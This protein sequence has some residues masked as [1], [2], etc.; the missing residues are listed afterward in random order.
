MMK[1]VIIGTGAAGISA[2]ETIRQHD[3]QGKIILI[4]DE[5]DG[6][7]SRPG[8]AYLLTSEIPESQLFP[9]SS[10]DFRRLNLHMFKK[11]AGKID[12]QSRK[13]VLQSG[14]TVSYDR[15]LIATGAEARS[16]RVPGV[17]L[18]GVVKLDNVEDARRIIHLAK[19]TRAAVVIGGGITALEIVEGLVHK[20]VKV[21]FF[22]RGD[23]YWGNV[24]DEIESKIVEH[25]LK[26]EGVNI[27][28]HTELEEIIGK[29]SGLFRG[30][31]LRVSA[32][33][34]KA[35]KVIPCAMVAIA[36]GIVPR[37]QLAKDA[38]LKTD[39]GILVDEW[40][41]SDAPDIYAAGDVAQ[42]F[43]PVTGK[44]V[45]DSLW[46]P[47]RLQGQAAGMN[48][49][50]IRTAYRKDFPFNVTRLAGLTTTIIGAVGGKDPDGW[51]RPVR[52]RNLARGP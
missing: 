12:R 48:M 43:D 34:T 21:H 13:V 25:R 52:Q 2:A 19:K 14:E 24:L 18:K 50:G 5:P 8:L 9:F 42:V 45:I 44:S 23:R 51:H 1:Y 17:D 36:I 10:D 47:A 26:E 35:G 39:R 46:G 33:R 38:G 29:R 16:A 32:V 30:G 41:Q 37:I 31:E 40:M 15:L 27:H 20:G 49:V 22:L 11:R 28:Y 6:Y 7:Y 4:G 3:S